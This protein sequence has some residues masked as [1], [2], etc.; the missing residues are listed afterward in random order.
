[1]FRNR[2]RQQRQNLGVYLLAYQL[3]TAGPIPPVTLGAI[4]LQV[5]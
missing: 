2:Q 1:M 5:S 3:M 4:A